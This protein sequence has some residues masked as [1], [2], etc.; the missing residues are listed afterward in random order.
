M[1]LSMIIP[2][3]ALVIGCSSTQITV[4]EA[5]TISYSHRQMGTDQIGLSWNSEPAEG[6]GR[7]VDASM[8]AV[9]NPEG[10]SASQGTL[11]QLIKTGG[12]TA[13][14]SIAGVP[15]AGAG[16]MLSTLDWSFLPFVGP[17]EE[18]MREQIIRDLIVES[19]LSEQE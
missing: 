17:S 3:I 1:R 12:S 18:E 6:G 16:A 14:G 15:G 10:Q 8:H 4:D 2:L 7:Y 5:G 9:V 19:W 13:L 11:R